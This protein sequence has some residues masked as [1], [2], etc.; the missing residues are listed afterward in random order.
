VTAQGVLRAAFTAL[1]L[2][3]GSA[4]AW[5]ETPTLILQNRSGQNVEL[6]FV[7]VN[8]GTQGQGFDR[9]GQGVLADGGTFG[10][11][12]LRSNQCR[13]DIMT[14]FTDRRMREWRNHD[15]CAEPR[16]VVPRCDA[17]CRPAFAPTPAPR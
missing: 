11:A 6:L 5:A 3:A 14:V 9:L 2:L 7:V 10:I 13:W 12:N 15:L 16:I 4:G 17:A 1:A 8:G